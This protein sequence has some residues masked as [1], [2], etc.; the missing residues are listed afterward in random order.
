[1]LLHLPR[2]WEGFQPAKLNEDDIDEVLDC[3]TS[4][5][6]SLIAP[7]YLESVE[8]ADAP[9]DDFLSP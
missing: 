2:N 7:F 4:G 8:L 3:N 6:P 1:M 9:P 5:I